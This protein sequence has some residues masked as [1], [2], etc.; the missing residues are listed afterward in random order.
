VLNPVDDRLSED[1]TLT[2]LVSAS[3]VPAQS[4][5]PGST[6]YLMTLHLRGYRPDRDV[7]NIQLFSGGPF[8]VH[9]AQAGGLADAAINGGALE[10]ALHDATGF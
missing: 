5:V 6:G 1:G 7:P 10:Q 8:V 2:M 3:I 4:V 9:A